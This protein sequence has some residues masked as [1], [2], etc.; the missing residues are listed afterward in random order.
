[1]VNGNV[2]IVLLVVTLVILLLVGFF[3]LLLVMGNNR[4]N[5]HRAELAEVAVQ[6]AEEV[7]QVEQEVLAQTM[8]DVGR[9]LHDNIGQLLTAIRMGLNRLIGKEESEGGA[10]VKAT[11]DRT[12]AEVRRLSR[13]LNTDRWSEQDLAQAMAAECERVRHTIGLPV[14]FVQVG[15][16]AFQTADRKVVLYRI[17]QELLNNALKHAQATR[18]GVSLDHSTGLRLTVEDDGKGFDPQE[19]AAGQGLL[20]IRK[21]AA[22]IGY[23]CELHSAPGQGTRISLH[24]A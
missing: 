23:Q 24:E 16:A 5:R 2:L 10:E 15:E 3:V 4:R 22:L 19:A 7:R 21:R 14:V 18:I 12:I 17:F 1:M 9:D 6:H 11:V 20:N 13:T 8:A